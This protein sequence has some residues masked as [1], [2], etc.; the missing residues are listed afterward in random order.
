MPTCSRRRPGLRVFSN[1]PHPMLPAWSA[2]APNSIRA[3]PIP[4]MQGIPSSVFPAWAF[5]CRKHFRDVSARAS[6]IFP[7]CRPETTC[8]KPDARRSG[9]RAW[10]A[11]AGVPRGVR[12]APPSPRCGTFMAPRQRGSP[13]AA[14][15][16]C[17]R[18]CACAGRW[19]QQE[20]KPPFPLSTGSAAG[21]SW[22]AAALHGLLELIERDAASLWWQGGSRG[23]SIP[24]GDEAEIMAETLLAQLRQGASARRSWL[25]DITTDIG[26][27]CVAADLLHGGWLWLCLWAGRAADTQ[28]RCPLRRSGNVP[29]RT[30][31]CGGRSEA[32]G[33]RR[34]RAERAGPNSPAACDDAERR[35]VSAAAAGAGALAHLAIDIDRSGAPCCG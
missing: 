33:A 11:G 23:K 29:G 8:W 1:S 26:V 27:P 32:P 7:S 19:H 21:Q 20:V 10:S 17:R 28:G 35:S 14:R 5:R 24:P 31:P 9:S 22:D 25:L 13:T 30:G 4:S 3:S 16:C 2:L 12:G 18:I 15:S 34:G 6:S